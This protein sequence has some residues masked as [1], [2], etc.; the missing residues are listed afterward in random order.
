MA[1]K[2]LTPIGTDYGI[3]QEAYVRIK[4]YNISKTG[5]INLQLEIFLSEEDF[6]KG[7]TPVRNRMIG[8]SLV[9]DLGH[10]EI[11]TETKTIMATPGSDTPPPTNEEGLTIMPSVI[12][13]PVAETLTITTTVRVIDLS[14][15][16][17]NSIFLFGYSKLKEK[18]VTLFNEDDIIDC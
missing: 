16:E 18:L 3:A 5:A 7:S 2:I 10:D 8:D 17:Q 12:A 11:V 13:E 15:L 9:L 6:K 14:Y 4:E 1:I